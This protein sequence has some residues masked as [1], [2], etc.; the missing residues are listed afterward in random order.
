MDTGPRGANGASPFI[1][2]QPERD[3][4]STPAAMP[5]L[6]S[7]ATM[8]WLTLTVALTDEPQNRLIVA[9]GTLVSRCSED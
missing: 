6:R 4:D 9:P 2:A 7:P 1:S 3:I 8:A 5:R